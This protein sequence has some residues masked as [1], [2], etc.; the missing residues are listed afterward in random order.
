MRCIVR[1]GAIAGLIL[2]LAVPASANMAKIVWNVTYV[3]VQNNTGVGFDD[4]VLGAQRR[5]TLE[6]ALAYINTV[7]CDNGPADLVINA[8]QTDGTG[9]LASAGPL[10]FVAPNGFENGHLFDHA[11]TGIDPNGGA[12]P[13]ASATFDFGYNWNSGQGN[14]AA[15]EFDLFSVA[16]HEV[17]H[18]MGFLSLVDAAGLSGINGTNPGV[19]S[20]FDSFLER[21]NGVALFGPGGTYNG[22]AGDLT[23]GDVF[24]AGPN[25]FA[26]NGGA[27]VQVYAPNPFA[28]GSSISHIDHTA[29]PNS[30][31]NF[32]IGPGDMR[33]AYSAIEVAILQDIG[34]DVCVIPEPGSFL[35]LATGSAML[36]AYTRRKRTKH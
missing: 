33:R 11:T 13:D 4:A 18:A 29:H 26:A 30:L 8:S 35:L 28:P 34:W 2:V 24:F 23:S 21:G 3:D 10:F 15:N 14:A 25:A 16:L 31:M 12:F 9:F 36:C 32:A 7:I 1:G 5:Q 27:P 6:A 19:F 20:V 22:N 17:T